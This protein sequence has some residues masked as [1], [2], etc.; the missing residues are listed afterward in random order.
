MKTA[1][2]PH[3]TKL[4]VNALPKACFPH[5][6]FS[7]A[8]TATIVQDDTKISNP[9][10]PHGR[11]CKALYRQLL[12]WCDDTDQSI[13]LSKFIPP[14]HMKPPQVH[15]ASLR[16]AAAAQKGSSSSSVQENSISLID[17]LPPNILIKETELTVPIANSSDAKQFLRA[18]FRM[19]AYPP[20]DET[21]TKTTGSVFLNDTVTMRKEQVSMA[22]EGLRNLN[23]LSTQKLAVLIDARNKHR[24]RTGVTFRVGQVV[25]HNTQKWRGVVF[26]W[27]RIDTK[28]EQKDRPA[29]SLTKKSYQSKDSDK[30]STISCIVAMDWGDAAIMHQS[31]R[32]VRSIVDV[33]ESEL[34]LVKDRDLLRIRSGQ[35]GEHF[36]RFDPETKCFV[37]GVV[38]SFVYPSDTLDEEWSKYRNPSDPAARELVDGIQRM[39]EY[40]RNIILGYTSAPETLKLSILS[41]F[42][43]RFTKIARGDVI[44][45]DERFDSNNATTQALMKHHLQQFV[46]L[47][48]ELNDTLWTRRKSMETSRTIQFSLGQVVTH[49]KYGFRGVVVAWDAEPVYDVTNWDGL[50]HIDNP[51]RYPF[52]HVIPDPNDTMIAFGG[53]RAWRYVCEDNLEPCPME[54]RN[55]DV[56]LEPEWNFD[57]SAGMYVPPDDLLFRHGGQLNDDGVTENCLKKLKETIISLLICIRESSTMDTEELAKVSKQMSIDNLFDVL[58]NAEDSETATVITDSFKELWKAHKEDDIRFKFDTGVNYLLKGKTEEALALFSEV[59]NVDPSYAEAYNKAST[60]EYMI[61]NL[62]A[63]LAAA[64]KTLQLNPKHFQALNGLGLVYNEKK[65]LEFAAEAFRKSMDLDPWSPVAGRLSV[66]LDTLERWRKTTFKMNKGNDATEKSKP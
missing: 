9:G 12:R 33:N 31:N 30:D 47:V 60:A 6:T 49:K 17:Y 8:S 24:D 59:V 37:P 2:S 40:S 27:N 56:D 38:S 25:K 51:E 28:Q 46:N 42:L 61:G 7:T 52:Y 4:T 43:D 44:P 45:N 36:E 13:P 20:D 21:T 1:R 53:E 18:I 54:S 5:R 14:L 48:V 62:D 29:T 19:N 3:N 11:I 22:F 34:S 35:L 15:P 39:A 55:I 26:G 63:S 65:D 50:Q 57:D 10:D 66:C 32:P 23:E 58:K 16:L 64:H 41:T